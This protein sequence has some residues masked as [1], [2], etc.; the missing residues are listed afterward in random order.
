[1]PGPLEVI[2]GAVYL[3]DPESGG[4]GGVAAKRLQISPTGAAG[5]LLTMAVIG[6]CCSYTAVRRTWAGAST[7]AVGVVAD[8]CGRANKVPVSVGMPG[9]SAVLIPYQHL[10]HVVDGGNVWRL[11]CLDLQPLLPP[12]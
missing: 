5:G 8:H 1:M 9:C 2:A 3:G 4:S 6:C 11:A 12:H 7:F 10:G